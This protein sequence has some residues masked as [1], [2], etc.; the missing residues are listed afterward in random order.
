MEYTVDKRKDVYTILDELAVLDATEIQVFLP[1]GS[2]IL[3]NRLNLEFLE[4][5]LEKLGKSISF[6]TDDSTGIELLASMTGGTSAEYESVGSSVEEG[7]HRD[8]GKLGKIG[9]SIFS[10]FVFKLSSF[11]FPKLPIPK[12]RVGFL[13]IFVG[14]ILLGGIAF[15]ATRFLNS[16]K[17]YVKLIVKQESLARSITVLVDADLPKETDVEL[18]AFKGKQ[19]T[20]TFTEEITQE[21]TGEKLEGES[22]SGEVLIYNRTESD[23]KLKKGAVL[24]FDSDG[25]DLEFRLTDDVT[26]P[27]VSYKN[28]EDPASVMIPGEKSADVTASDIGP[29]YNI[30]KNE[31]LEVLGYKKTELA[32]KSSSDFKGGSSK[33]IKVVSS[34]DIEAAISKAR[35]G[36]DT[37]VASGLVDSVGSGY[38]Y[39][40]GSAS[41]SYEDLVIDKKAGD[42]AVSFKVAQSAYVTGLSYSEKVLEKLIL[43]L[44]QEFV[45]ESFE[46][47]GDNIEISASSLGNSDETTVTSTKADLQVTA[48]TTVVPSIDIEDLKGKLAGKGITEVSRI[49]GGI[50]TLSTYEFR[51]EPNLP[52]SQKVPEDLDRILVEIVEEK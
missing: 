41:T 45:P 25:T 15:G 26:I 50:R 24:K 6:F 5:S 21:A 3:E 51:L 27:A 10:G 13:P 11:E 46:P 12:L 34:E 39:I 38:K 33:T 32:A 49:L 17:A 31:T 36:L 7:E 37:K 4:E 20:K 44:L 29:D 18:K 22:A 40:D 8:S 1:S 43:A 42:E 19:V 30:K 23:V 28:P 47:S 35:T 2:L 16:Q 14:L 48:K 52:F 9:E